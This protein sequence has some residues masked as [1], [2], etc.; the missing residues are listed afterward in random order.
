MGMVS[1]WGG[2]VEPKRAEVAAGW[3][4]KWIVAAAEMAS[5]RLEASSG[6]GSWG[7][8]RREGGAGRSVRAEVTS[9][10]AEVA[11]ERRAEVTFGGMVDPALTGKRSGTD[12]KR[13]LRT[14]RK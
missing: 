3:G 8:K 10:S 9:G 12:R 11:S 4:R 2:I 5:R 14:D 1:G 13:V 6:L 7:F